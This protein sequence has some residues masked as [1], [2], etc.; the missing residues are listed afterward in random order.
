MTGKRRRI[1]LYVILGI[2]SGFIILSIF[3]FFVPGFIIDREFSQEVQ[4]TQNH[5][6]DNSMTAVSIVGNMPYS[7]IMVLCTAA[8]FFLF[9]YKRESLFVILTGLSGAI[10]TL[11]KLVINRPRPSEPLVRV[12]GKNL[13]QS[14]PSGHV[15]FY[16]VFFGFITVLMFRLAAI[17]KFLR[18]FFASISVLMIFLVCFSRIYL[19]A[20][21]F[22][23]VLGG[24]LL[25]LL[26]L[27]FL[28][29]FYMKNSP[30][31]PITQA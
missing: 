22:T 1:I 17:P 24:F 15:M 21:W 7:V 4:E 19:G 26:C 27:Y 18:I 30:G 29:Y 9:R 13:Q 28:S 3:V 14:F 10:S 11:I 23:D 12:L 20:H 8:V 2:A 31:Q 25:G 6:L 16:I 5:F